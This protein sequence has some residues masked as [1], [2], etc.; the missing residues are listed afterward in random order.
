MGQ[1]LIVNILNKWKNHFRIPFTDPYKIEYHYF[2]HKCSI[3]E[4]R[5]A[6][7]SIR[8]SCDYFNLFL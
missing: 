5:S 7:I 6:K 8:R 4:S 1:V 3:T 2:E